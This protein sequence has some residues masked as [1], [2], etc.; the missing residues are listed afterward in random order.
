APPAPPGSPAACPRFP[1]TGR[2]RRA[3]SAYS[4][5]PSDSIAWPVRP[6]RVTSRDRL[7]VAETGPELDDGAWTRKSKKDGVAETSSPTRDVDLRSCLT[8]PWL[9]HE[10]RND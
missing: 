8:H 9:A 7:G 5:A 1:T 4:S 10:S 6:H 3:G 2:C